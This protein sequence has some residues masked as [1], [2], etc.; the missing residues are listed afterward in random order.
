MGATGSEFLRDSY[1]GRGRRAAA[2]AT[3]ALMAVSI[4]RAVSALQARPAA[5]P[6]QSRP[7]DRA[8]VGTWTAV[9]LPFGRTSI[10]TS[11]ESG[12]VKTRTVTG[13]LQIDNDPRHVWSGPAL[14]AGASRRRRPNGN[15]LVG[16][17][18]TLAA[19]RSTT[20]R[21]G[22]GQRGGWQRASCRSGLRSRFARALA[23][24]TLTAVICV[25]TCSDC[26]A[27]S[28]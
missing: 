24:R 12:A 25:R 26:V 27:S 15:V 13:L 22:F 16:E 20:T 18:K 4:R 28:N 1:R 6:G 2:R 7:E 9:H 3:A 5:S 11:Y 21:S 19:G 10:A 8:G 14:R 17:T 23:R